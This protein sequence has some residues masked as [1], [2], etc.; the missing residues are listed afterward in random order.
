MSMKL[1][2][3]SAALAASFVAM[4]IGSAFADTTVTMWTF[5][6]PSKAGGRE[7]ALKTMIEGF[8]KA[9]PGI[10]IKVEPQVWTTLA[11]KFVLGSNA[12]NAPDIGWVNA[13]NL[14]LVVNSDAAADL[15][16]IVVD[17]WSAERKADLVMPKS[18]DA[19]TLDGKILAVPLMSST[20]VMMYRKDLF[21]AAGIDVKSIETWDGVTAAAKKLTTDKVWGMGL[22]L[23]SERFSATPSAMAAFDASDG[24]FDNDCKVKFDNEGSQKAVQLQVDWINKDKVSPRESLSMTSDDAIDQFSAGRY[25]MEVV[26]NSRFE[27]IQRNA[28]G[29]NKDDL[30]MAPIPGWTAGKLGPEIASGWFAVAWRKSPNLDA[31]AKFIDYMSSAESMALW[32]IPGGQVPMMKSVAARPEMNEPQNAPL[33]D[34][35]GFLEANARFTPGACNWSRTYADFNLATQQVVLG[36]LSVA[37]AVK[38]AAKATQ[39]RQ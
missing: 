9:N 16:P 6:D 8:E 20:W 33:K 18:L 11:E 22:G 25:A 15:K 7:S 13:E 10:H 29:W 28:A 34:V 37:D 35:A 30:G 5:L 32:N 27:Q 39:D 3:I 38:Q 26:A 17:K 2:R 12:G 36:Q 14:G 21:K 19:V 4:G 31:A 1:A 24:F 23:A